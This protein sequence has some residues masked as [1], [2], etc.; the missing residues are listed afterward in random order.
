M[1][2]NVEALL[3]ARGCR[4]VFVEDLGTA[5]ALE[6]TVLQREPSYRTEIHKVFDSRKKIGPFT[7]RNKTSVWRILKKTPKAKA[8]GAAFLMQQMKLVDVYAFERRRPTALVRV[9][10]ERCSVLYEALCGRSRF[11]L[12][13]RIPNPRGEGEIFSP[14][15]HHYVDI[16]RWM[17][18]YEEFAKKGF[19]L[20]WITGLSRGDLLEAMSEDD[21]CLPAL[22]FFEVKDG[23]AVLCDKEKLLEGVLPYIPELE[24]FRREGAYRRLTAEQ[25]YR[26]GLKYDRFSAYGTGEKA[27]DAKKAFLWYAAAAVEGHLCAQVLLGRLYLEG[28]GACEI[29]RERGLYWM[30]KASFNRRYNE[31]FA[32]KAQEQNRDHAREVLMRCYLDTPALE[33]M[34]LRVGGD[35]G[36][37]LIQ[38]A[39]LLYGNNVPSLV[40]KDLFRA[41]ME[42]ALNKKW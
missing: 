27:G 11:L 21:V 32:D 41:S 22:S 8:E 38:L 12:T 13:D 9:Q 35:D 25:K 15:H 17:A 39:T 19:D 5:R 26:E 1:K 6:E 24:E 16:A 42:R 23:E 29:D 36:K 20:I 31:R 37:H 40:D 3:A 34:I 30:A 28:H 7:V 2:I 10:R 18:G 33:E 14:L 4:I